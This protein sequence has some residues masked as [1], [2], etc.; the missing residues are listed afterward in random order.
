M[1]GGTTWHLQHNLPPKKVQNSTADDPQSARQGSNLPKLALECGLSTIAD[2]G[3]I[4]KSLANPWRASP[5]Q[6]A[7]ECP[8]PRQPTT[9]YSVWHCNRSGR[10]GGGL[11]AL[12][13]EAEL[14]KH[15]E[16]RQDVRL[17]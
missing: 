6:F 12:R 14:A 7:L 4:N 3:G 8:V 10:R 1:G 9:R 5:A 2:P 13:I 15:L 17:Q 16:F 11:A